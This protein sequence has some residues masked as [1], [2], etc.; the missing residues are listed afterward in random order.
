MTRKGRENG[1]FTKGGDKLNAKLTV[2]EVAHIRA[3]QGMISTHELSLIYD[4]TSSA[5]RDIWIGKTWK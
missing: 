5:I 2:E 4:V 3:S 1:R